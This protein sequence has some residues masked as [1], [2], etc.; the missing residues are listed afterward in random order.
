MDSGDLW[1]HAPSCRARENKA[2]GAVEIGPWRP[3]MEGKESEAIHS[4]VPEERVHVLTPRAVG[5]GPGMNL[6]KVSRVSTC[7][8]GVP[9]SSLLW[10]STVIKC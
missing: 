2:H 3:H 8:A 5:L 6:G 7:F 4:L 9:R 1:G 10:N